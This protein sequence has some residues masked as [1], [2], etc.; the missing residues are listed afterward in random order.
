MMTDIY[1]LCFIITT[2]TYLLRWTDW[3]LI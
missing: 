3:L 1:F 2:S